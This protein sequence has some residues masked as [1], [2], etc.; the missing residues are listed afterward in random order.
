MVIQLIY[1]YFP[2]A[3]WHYLSTFIAKQVS[4]V[5]FGVS[6]LLLYIRDPPKANESVKLKHKKKKKRDRDDVW[7]MSGY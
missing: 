2:A 3:H 5:V 7:W 4:W 6:Q 1:I